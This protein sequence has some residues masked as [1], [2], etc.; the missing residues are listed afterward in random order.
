VPAVTLVI[1]VVLALAGCGDDQDSAAPTGELSVEQA[2]EVE[3]DTPVLVRGF[4]VVADRARLCS[5]LAESYPPQC[6][7][8]S[9]VV[10]DLPPRELE[11]LERAEGV[12]WSERQVTLRGLVDDGVLGVIEHPG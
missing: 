6:G 3:S 12:A 5:A 11:R 1:L 2:L 10:E 9:L 7:G 8:P 4:L